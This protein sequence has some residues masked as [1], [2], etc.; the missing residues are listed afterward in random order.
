MFIYNDYVAEQN[1]WVSEI[2]TGRGVNFLKSPKPNQTL[3]SGL[4]EK[5]VIPSIPLSSLKFVDL[6]LFMY[7]FLAWI[8]QM[9]YNMFIKFIGAVREILFVLEKARLTVSPFL[10][11]MLG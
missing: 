6:P 8:K 7:L 5:Y 9:R 3:T 4:A 10:V 1:V 11:F 2:F